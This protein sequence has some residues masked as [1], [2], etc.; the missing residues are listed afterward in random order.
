MAEPASAQTVHSLSPV[1][2]HIGGWIGFGPDGF[3]YWQ[4]GDA[5]MFQT[6]DP[7]NNAQ[8][9]TGE[10]FGNVLRIDVDGDDF[11]GDGS[12]NY[13]VPADSP[14]VGPDF[15]FDFQANKDK[16]THERY[17]LKYQH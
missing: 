12:R 5:G 13:S 8:S 3:L 7:P 17:P 1:L 11:P 14:F 4:V 9:I 15:V 6:W 2:G 16:G 10:L